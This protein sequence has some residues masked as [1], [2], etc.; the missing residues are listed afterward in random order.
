MAKRKYTKKSDYWKRFGG[1]SASHAP[2]SPALSRSV[3]EPDLVGE[4]FYTSD[5]SY[6]TVS[7]A[8]AGL[9]ENLKK[10]TRT[11]RVAYRNP[12]DRFASIRVGLLPYDYASDGVN[13]RDGIELFFAM[14]LI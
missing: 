3:P 7:N 10:G 5:A 8:R 9:A 13:V 11:N 6:N 14:L 4:P 12:S 2:Q 1:E